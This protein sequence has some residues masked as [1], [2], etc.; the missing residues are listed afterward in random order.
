MRRRRHSWR[1]TRPGPAAARRST[2]A[3]IAIRA[4]ARLALLARRDDGGVGA[5]RSLD[6][7]RARDCAGVAAI[8]RTA[9]S[10]SALVKLA[11]WSALVAGD[12]PRCKADRE[13]YTALV[14]IDPAVWLSLDATALPGVALG[15]QG[16]AL[17]RWGRDRVC[18]EGLEAAVT[19]GPR[20][21]EPGRSWS[22]SA[23]WGGERDRAAAL[24]TSDRVQELS[25]RVGPRP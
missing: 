4:A 1:S 16:M 20:R 22:L 14:V 25:C 2:S 19:R 21:G 10:P 15:H 8:D 18:L 6:G 12:D 7:P 5:A 17:V 23:R 9:A 13:A 11:P 24:R 3:W